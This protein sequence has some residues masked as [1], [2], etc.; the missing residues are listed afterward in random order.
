M[1]R[2]GV[3]KVYEAK[4]WRKQGVQSCV[5]L[6]S[7][8]K[9]QVHQPVYSFCVV[10][11]GILVSECSWKMSSIVWCICHSICPLPFPSLSIDSSPKG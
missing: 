6:L 10:L 1:N 3:D 7:S 2:D 4:Y 11:W 9:I 5:A 8:V